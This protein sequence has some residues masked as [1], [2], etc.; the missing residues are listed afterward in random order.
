M[1]KLDRFLEA[2]EED[3]DTALKEI[4]NGRK[5]SCW[6]WYIFPQIKGLGM[7][8]MSNKYGIENIEEAIEYL[9]N[10]TLRKRIIEISQALL[11]LE[12]NNIHVIIGYPDDLKLRSSMTL[13]KKAEELSEI[14]CDNIFQKVLDKF[15]NGEE[16]GKTIEILEKQN[17]KK[18]KDNINKENIE[19]ENTNISG[20]E[21]KNNE[22][23]EKTQENKK[24]KTFDTVP[25]IMS[26]DSNPQNKETEQNEKSKIKDISDENEEND[27]KKNKQ[28]GCA[29]KLCDLCS[30]M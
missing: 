24:I 2:Q 13:F 19:N 20:N 18:Q 9:K 28:K 25:T 29:D 4:K 23:N 27:D 22:E 5:S 17:E 14:K 3:Y 26:A 10:E 15:Y 11:D 16:D 8:Q 6:M 7:T 12:E 1:S 30:I 21:N